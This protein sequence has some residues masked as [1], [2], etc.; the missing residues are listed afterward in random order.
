VVPVSPDHTVHPVL[1]CR[2]PGLLLAE[3][4]VA[5]G[6]DV[7]LIHHVHP[8]IVIQGVCLG[9]LGIMACAYHIDIAALHHQYVLHRSLHRDIFAMTRMDLVTVD[10]FE[11]DLLPIDIHPAVHNLYIPE[12]CSVADRL[13]DLAGRIF[14]HDLKCIEM[15]LLGRPHQRLTDIHF[16]TDHILFSGCHLGHLRRSLGHLPA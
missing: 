15:R 2:E 5:V 6:L 11:P 10:A 3:G 7:R 13:H 1:E 4:M 8:V 16:K 9:A 14:K 12:S